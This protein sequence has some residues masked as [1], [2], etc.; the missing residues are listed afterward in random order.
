MLIVKACNTIIIRRKMAFSVG[1]EIKQSILWGQGVCCTHEWVDSGKPIQE[2]LL[3]PGNPP[4]HGPCQQLQHIDLHEPILPNPL[5]LCLGFRL[6]DLL[7][8]SHFL[9]PFLDTSWDPLHGPLPFSIEPGAALAHYV[10]LAA[11]GFLSAS[12]CSILAIL[13]NGIAQVHDRVGGH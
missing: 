6:S 9:I 4:Q 3:Q 8:S 1:L 7:F 12:P 10:G 5:S 11:S 2:I 13:M